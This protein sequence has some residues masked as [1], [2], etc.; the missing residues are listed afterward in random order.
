MYISGRSRVFLVDARPPGPLPISYR[1]I[2][3]LILYGNSCAS[4]RAEAQLCGMI[5]TIL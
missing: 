3:A 5:K 1:L 2:L 4:L